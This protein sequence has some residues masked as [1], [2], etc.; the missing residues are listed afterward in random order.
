MWT[1]ISL[2]WNLIRRVSSK[3]PRRA[4]PSRALASATAPG[5][6]AA[7]YP[8]LAPSPQLRVGLWSGCGA[9]P[10]RPQR[11]PCYPRLALAGPP[12]CALPQHPAHVHRFLRSPP[13]ALRVAG[14]AQALR[15]AGACILPDLSSFRSRRP[16]P[17][18][19]HIWSRRARS[20]FPPSK[21][22]N[23]V[24]LSICENCQAQLQK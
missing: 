22:G 1:Q 2:I 15:R 5:A 14:S 8:E 19:A 18:M 6:F 3:A 12:A 20:N 21:P 13:R 4:L 16:W 10:T 24:T 9:S 11:V 23:S 17:R 7:R